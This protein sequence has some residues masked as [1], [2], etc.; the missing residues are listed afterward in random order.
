MFV[1]GVLYIICVEVVHDMFA[2]YF[3]FLLCMALHLE[4]VDS[5]DRS[6]IFLS[7]VVTMP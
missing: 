6:N 3:V 4:Y 1:F 7:F 5:N 2:I